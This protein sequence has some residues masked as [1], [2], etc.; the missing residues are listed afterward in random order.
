MS[1]LED[2]EFDSDSSEDEDFVPD[3]A[4]MDSDDGA[5]DDDDD[6]MNDN[7]GE[8]GEDQDPTSGKHAKKPASKAKK[9]RRRKQKQTSQQQQQQASTTTT[10]EQDT[11]DQQARKRRIDALW[12]DLK[13]SSTPQSA[14][15]SA[16]TKAAGLRAA[17]SAYGA[18]HGSTTL[19]S[20][21]TTTTTTTGAASSSSS[22]QVNMVTIT[23]TYDFAGE[24]VTVTKEVPENSKEAKDAAAKGLIKGLPGATPTT[25]TTG[26]SSSSANNNGSDKKGEEEG[27]KSKRKRD[28]DDG[29]AGSTEDGPKR[30]RVRYVRARSRLDDLAALYGVKRPAT[31]NTL[32]KS[33]LDWNSF[34]GKEGIEDEL[35]HHNKDGYMEKTAFLDRA[36]AHKVQEIKALRRKR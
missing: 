10:A 23:M 36:Y 33:K 26:S 29:S 24:K 35:K 12:D 8:V 7:I 32:E 9:G 30:I 28:N 16:S 20:P 19:S 15:V 2:Q 21:A 22:G 18:A 31:L 6:D 27:E 13:S 25:A 5:S 3:H 11:T 34:V 17:I 1:K 4:D 14:S